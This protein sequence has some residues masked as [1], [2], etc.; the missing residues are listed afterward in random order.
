[1]LKVCFLAFGLACLVACNAPGSGAGKTNAPT[2]SETQ[3]AQRYADLIRAAKPA[4]DVSVQSDGVQ[5]RDGD[6]EYRW[7]SHNAYQEYR[8]SP[9][10]LDAILNRHLAAAFKGWNVDHRFT[11]DTVLACVRGA[12]DTSHTDDPQ[13]RYAFNAIAGDLRQYFCGDSETG[14][15]LLNE[16]YVAQLRQSDPAFDRK[17]IA[18]VLTLSGPV[19]FKPTGG[20]TLVVSGGNYES[21]L[22]LV[23]KVWETLTGRHGDEL[24]FV[25]P[26]RDLFLVAAISDLDGI[27]RM[28][29]SAA[30]FFERSAYAIS[31]LVY[32]YYNGEISVLAR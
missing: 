8:G 24:A 21:S 26:A 4:A 15:S 16:S 31:P 28:K 9:D 5:V 6:V 11:S 29:A 2:L 27:A 32:R 30:D 12:I 19:K 17:I 13:Q 25:L 20:M 3:L 10:Q 22:I 7:Q 23:P 1:M 14:V 18:N